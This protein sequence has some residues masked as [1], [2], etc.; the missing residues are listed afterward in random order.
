MVIRFLI[1]LILAVIAS[2][3]WSAV[4]LIARFW[5]NPH[6]RDKA[7]FMGVMCDWL[8]LIIIVYFIL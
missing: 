6:N 8:I 7:I 3:R 1:F 2:V 5:R 4:Y